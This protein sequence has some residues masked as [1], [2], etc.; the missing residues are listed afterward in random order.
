L[1]KKRR[2]EKKIS[3]DPDAAER[4]GGKENMKRSKTT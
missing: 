1:K 2:T 3:L 4:K